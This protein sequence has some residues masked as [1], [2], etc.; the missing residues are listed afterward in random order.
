MVGHGKLF[1]FEVSC[2]TSSAHLPCNPIVDIFHGRTWQIFSC[3]RFLAPHSLHTSHVIPSLIFFMVGHDKLFLF[4]VSCPTSSAHIPCCLI[5]GIFHGGTR[6]TFSVWG[7]L[8]HILCTHPML[9]HRWYFS[10][11]DTTNFFCLRFV[12]PHPLH[13]SHVVSSLVFF[14]AGH[15]KLFLFEVSCP[16]SSAHLPCNPIVDIFHGR[17]WQIFSCL[18]FLAPHSLHTSHVIPS[19]IFFMVGHDKLFLFEVSCPTSPAYIP[20]CPIG[21]VHGGTRQPFSVWGL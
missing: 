11:W 4:E 1:M 17:T 14:M 9:S 8:P 7:F 15:D 2:P 6:Q 18:R 21:I 10:W 12:A 20:C 3:L 13:T 16:T 5:V 19:L